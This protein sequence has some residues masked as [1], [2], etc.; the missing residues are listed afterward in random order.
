MCSDDRAEHLT[1]LRNGR[2]TLWRHDD[3][4]RGLTIRQPRIVRG[5]M[6]L[7]TERR[8]SDA[9]TTSQGFRRAAGPAA[10]TQSPASSLNRVLLVAHGTRH[11]RPLTPTALAFADLAVGRWRRSPATLRRVA[12]FGPLSGDGDDARLGACSAARSS[13]RT[14]LGGA[15]VESTIPRVRRPSRRGER[16]HHK[17]PPLPDEEPPLRIRANKDEPLGRP[18]PRLE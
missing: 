16:L 1:L 17:L 12:S 8:E 5:C 10:T 15:V 7:L 9:L 11:H 6:E 4:R 13:R 2:L 18:P 3:R 14:D